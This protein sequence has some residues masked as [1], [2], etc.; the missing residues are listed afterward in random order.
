M[1][2]AWPAVL[3][4][5]IGCADNGPGASGQ[6]GAGQGGAGDGAGGEVSSGDGGSGASGHGCFSTETT[7]DGKCVDVMTNAEHCGECDNPCAAGPNTEGACV[8]GMCTSACAPGFADD[9]GVCK[10]FF[11]AHESYPATCAGCSTANAYSGSCS[12]PAYAPDLALHVQS[13]CPAIPMREKTELKLCLAGAVAPDSDFGGAYQVDDVDGWCGATAQCRVGNPLAGGA[14]ACP[15]GFEQNVAVR[16]I[17]RLPCDNSE[18]GTVIVFC[19]NQNAPFTSYAGAYQF[20]DLGTQCRVANPWT[21]ACSCPSGT[22]DRVF[23]AM[24]DGSAGL[25]GSTIH[26]CTP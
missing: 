13:D 14:C 7:C 3:L 15:A 23:R 9:G 1:R 20:D 4:F 6:G 21:G 11:G 2:R 10:N 22:T 12:C 26:L 16:S 18:A 5:V 25:Y 8:D 17:V 24:V 19:G